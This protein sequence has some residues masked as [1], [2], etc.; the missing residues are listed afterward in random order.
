MF[1]HGAPV[2]YC[3]FSPNGN[4]LVTASNT[5]T[6]DPL[7]GLPE[8]EPLVKAW[9]RATGQQILSRCTSRFGIYLPVDQVD[10]AR[11]L[12]LALSIFFRR[13]EIPSMGYVGRASAER[14]YVSRSCARSM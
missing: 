7:R 6:G 10:E 5:Q 11:R 12:A 3:M 2:N 14:R 13:W 9:E 4:W 8:L 1:W